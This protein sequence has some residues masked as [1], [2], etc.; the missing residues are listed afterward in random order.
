MPA[1]FHPIS[2]EEFAELLAR[3]PF[4]RRINS[5][6]M[7][8]TFI[9][10]QSQFRGRDSIVAMFNF[11]TRERGFSDIAQHITIAPDGVIWTG[12]NWNRSPA[13]AAGNNGN[14]LVGPFMFETIGNFDTGHER[15][16]EAQRE[17]VLQVIARVQIRFD[18]SPEMLRFHNQMSAKSCPG[19]S[20]DFD[21]TVDAVRDM[22]ARLREEGTR[23][24]REEEDAPF[25]REASTSHEMIGSIIASLSAESRAGN[26]SPDAELPEDEMSDTE[27]RSLTETENKTERVFAA[28]GV[29]RAGRRAPQLSPAMLS[30]LRPHVINLNNGVF[31]SSG[32]YS[33]TRGD[34]DAIFGEHLGKALEEANEENRK[35]RLVFYAH[36]GLTSESSG[37]HTALHHVS[38]WRKNNIYPIYFVWETGLFETLRGLF[39]GARSIV[40]RKATRDV[41]DY[42]SDAV[43][44][45]LARKLGGVKIWSGMKRS[46]ELASGENG[47]ARYVAEKLK[48]FCDANPE[49]LELHAVGHS[50]GSNFHAHF[51][52]A[53]LE[54]GIPSFRSLHFLAPAMRV[55]AFHKHLAQ[56]VGEG[57]NHLSIFTMKKD[58]ERADNC[59]QVYHKSLLYLIHHALEPEKGAP[60]LGLEKSLRDDAKLAQMFGLAG[61]SSED[62]EVIWAKSE[63]TDGRNASRATSHGGF[64]NDAA[65]M[66]S[67]A[68]RILNVTTQNI[69]G[70][71][72]EAASS[73]NTGF[74]ENQFELPEE[75]EFLTELP[76]MPT[77]NF[78][79][80]PL[81][82][83]FAP[84]HS[85]PPASA[86]NSNGHRLQNKGNGFDRR[87]LCVG[88]NTYPTAPLHGC[89]ADANTWEHTLRQ[90]GFQTTKLLDEQATRDAILDQLSDLVTTSRAGD[91]IVFQFAGHGTELPDADGDEIGGTNGGHDEA[92]CPHDFAG[93][94][95]VIDDDVAEIFRRLP[96][97]V[98]LTCFIDCCHSGTISRFAVGVT[99]A[100]E[101]GGAN[102]RPRF[103]IPNTQMVE[104]HR[105]FRKDKPKSRDAGTR[106]PDAMREVL[107]SACLDSE[108]AWESNGH[109][110]FTTFATPLL[111]QSDGVTNEEFERSVIAAFGA[112]PRQHPELDCAP[113]SRARVLLQPLTPD[114]H[115]MNNSRG[116][117]AGQSNTER[118]FDTDTAAHALRAI[119]S[120]LETQK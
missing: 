90:I 72:E 14:G 61:A 93:G 69:V 10:N 16:T 36:G 95:F 88:I 110:D 47:G 104:A 115:A 120:L 82:Q 107:F 20:I 21:E 85:S 35:L 12:R 81:P 76:A 68:R 70:F 48:A 57:I 64:D 4:T 28:H 40:Q 99:P 38:W 37:L 75:L 31:S 114:H 84:A 112:T 34:V 100:N 118:A 24:P 106:G 63:N 53:A 73:R 87:A 45:A 26:E 58:W 74:D 113:A 105:R 32:L 33:T 67:V 78:P 30:D 46:A 117:V 77:S 79:P 89:V 62:A 92:L 2:I 22:H 15:M 55:E 25:P 56:H 42:T 102:R 23:A 91:C 80:R 17:T 65:T 83:S 103:M 8:H 41:W 98:N 51:I 52:P 29:E 6:H 94:A 109:G 19:T 43:I 66:N 101:R 50:A 54:A 86:F 7:H 97:G 108:V 96:K 3:F 71:P 44:E 18:L 1:P 116:M 111:L 27:K 59:V 5:V 13:S 119:A 9:P 49:M 39:S 60:L 11:H